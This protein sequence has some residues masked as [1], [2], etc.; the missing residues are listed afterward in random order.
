[1]RTRLTTYK[2]SSL[3]VLLMLWSGTALAQ[4]VWLDEKGVRQYSDRPP[5]ASVANSRILKSPVT[6]VSPT[7]NNGP[8][9]PAATDGVPTAALDQQKAKTTDAPVA[10]GIDRLNADFNKRRAE[11]A[12]AA[13][14]AAERERATALKSK[15][16]ERA[17]TYL[18]TLESGAR[19]G[20]VEPNGERSF[21]S[22]EQRAQEIREASSMLEGCKRG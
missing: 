2:R 11:Q 14:K 16:C 21:L 7:G 4:Y 8:A 1:M 17:E 18:R 12:E 5:P 10:A 15:N 6:S 3:I 9:N 19:I 20:R 13:T 22:D